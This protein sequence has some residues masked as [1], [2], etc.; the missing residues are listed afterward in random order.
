MDHENW[1]GGL[2][3]GVED[4]D[5]YRMR[6]DNMSTKRTMGQPDHPEPKAALKELANRIEKLS[7]TDMQTLVE[8][9]KL[10]LNTTLS[11]TVVAQA[12]LQGSARAA[13]SLTYIK[14][15]L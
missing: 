10:S 11:S 2:R 4:P 12:L 1:G 7:Y 9:V 8:E 14:A 15:V 5:Y 3:F 13:N 6:E